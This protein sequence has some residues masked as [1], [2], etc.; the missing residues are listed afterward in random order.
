MGLFS[1]LRKDEP[2]SL[3]PGS[4]RDEIVLGDPEKA[5][6]DPSRANL[7]TAKSDPL[8]LQISPE[9]EKRVIRKLDRRLIS[10]VFV[11]CQ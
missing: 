11:L 6:V 1:R 10:L 5:G 8:P 7:E 9:I 4:V 2:T 3:G